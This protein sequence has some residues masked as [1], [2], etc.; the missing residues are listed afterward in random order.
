MISVPESNGDAALAISGL[1]VAYDSVPVVWNASLTIPTGRLVGIVG[2]NGA[3]KSSL[4]KAVLGL[5]PRVAG[6]VAS[7]GL[8]PARDP[9]RVAYVPQRSSV[10][11]DFPATVLDVVLMGTFGQLGWFKR[12]GRA[13][14]DA[15]REALARVEMDAYA[16]R[17]IA[18]LSGGQQQRVFIARALVQGAD[19]YLMDEPFAGV[20]ALTERTIIALLRELVASGRTI[21]CVHHDLATVPEYFD[22]VV[23]M[24][25]EIVRHGPVASAF[26]QRAI[27]RAYGGR[28]VREAPRAPDA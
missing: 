17:A 6:R 19:L 20:D 10:D 13:Q 16:D 14:R 8:D 28:V 18:D 26:E 12:P 27:E 21:L 7:F 9:R 1:T 2:P 25:R 15:A 22:D 11:W 23:L 5:V 24:N 4:I 3:G